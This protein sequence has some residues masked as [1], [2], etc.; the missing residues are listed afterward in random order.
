M[1]RTT[2]VDASGR[3]QISWYV[4]VLGYRAPVWDA[5]GTYCRRPARASLRPRSPVGA[6][7]VAQWESVRFT[8]GRSLVRSQPGPQAS[9]QV[10]GSDAS[11]DTARDRTYG[12]IMR[13]IYGQVAD[14]PYDGRSLATS[15]RTT[16]R[17]DYSGSLATHIA[18]GETAVV[19][20]LL[21]FSAAS[22][23]RRCRLLARRPGWSA[24]RLTVR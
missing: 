24:A 2:I 6:G 1:R 16:S 7:P 11:L 13:P 19:R 9:V 15:R 5:C 22:R 10:V 3:A 8:R 14:W 17:P 12:P 18:T 21:N 20:P 4:A 23:V